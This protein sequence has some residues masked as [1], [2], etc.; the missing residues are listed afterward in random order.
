[1]TYSLNETEDVASNPLCAYF[2]LK[3]Y[4]MVSLVSSVQELYKLIR[5]NIKTHQS[6]TKWLPQMAFRFS[7]MDPSM[8]MVETFLC[9]SSI[10]ACIS[11]QVFEL[12]LVPGWL[13]CTHTMCVWVCAIAWSSSWMCKITRMPKWTG[14]IY[15]LL[16]IRMN[17][18]RYCLK[19][20]IFHAKVYIDC[21]WISKTSTSC[22]WWC[23]T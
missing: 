23:T 4:V 2:V 1:M 22:A 3:I 15:S 16:S 13:N 8:N 20:D 12:E 19:C 18:F 10:K 9:S 7:Y 14:I 11:F 21:T 17:S 6:F 5:H